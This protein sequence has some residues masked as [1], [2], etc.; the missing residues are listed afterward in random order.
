MFNSHVLAD[1][2][3]MRLIYHKQN[4]TVTVCVSSVVLSEIKKARL[5]LQ[6][7]N[8]M[9]AVPKRREVG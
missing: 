8:G 6:V 7:V 4:G 1:R 5:R 3:V 2:G 9:S